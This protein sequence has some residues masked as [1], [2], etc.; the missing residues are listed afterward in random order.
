MLA[1]CQTDPYRRRFNTVCLSSLPADDG[2]WLVTLADTIL[3]PE[4]GGQPSDTGT[5][6]GVRVTHVSRDASGAL[7]H[8][9]DGP[10]DAGE[11]VVEVDWGR[12]YDHMQQHT[13][14]HL[15]T[16]VAQD[17]FGWATT[18]FHLSEG[19]S[20]VELDAASLSDDDLAAL[21]EAVNAHVRAPRD[22][23]S[24]LVEPADLPGLGVRTRGLPEGFAGPVRLVEID[25][26]DLNT[27][28]GTHVATTAE[29]Q[30]VALVGTER[31]R[32]G[33]RLYFLAGGRVF[34]ALTAARERERLLTRVLSVGPEQHAAAAERL[35]AEA[36][37]A[38]R[39]R[40]ALLAELAEAAG[41]AVATAPGPAAAWHRP[42][43]DLPLLGAV[44]RAALER[45]PDLLLLLTAG[46][47][48]G[49]FL[50]AGPDA[51]VSAA[52]P[53]VAA[54]LEGRGGGKGG[55]YQGKGS[56]VD[57]REEALRALTADASGAGDEPL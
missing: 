57:R 8:R 18:A 43:G 26:V 2:T 7:V 50:L 19:R 5:I 20:D 42:D 1:A 11:V 10:I 38:A 13:A 47:R 53:R 28:G 41:A 56:R 55:R 36:K 39:D 48:E 31:M 46:D 34:Q 32:G 12:R 21:E 33:T 14:Q 27:C 40:R 4:G 30:A 29:L 22:V 17:R 23:R 54:L 25:G 16:A 44:A 15:L 49:V 37:E 52:A 24:R 6:D 9:A 51:A 3:Y 45:R 35:A